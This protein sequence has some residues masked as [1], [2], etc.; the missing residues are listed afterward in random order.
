MMTIHDFQLWLERYGRAWVAGEPDAAVQL[1]STDAAYYEEPF[2]DPMVGAGAIH[3]YW[4]EGAKD[5]QTDVAFEATAIFANEDT[6]FARWR[7]SFRRVPSRALVELDGVMW[8][9]FDEHMRCT[10]F[11]EWWH[12]R[13]S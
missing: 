11:R 5:G 8:A 4:T 9:R 2:D 10:E 6:G 12:R 1:F 7:A 3:R 13:E